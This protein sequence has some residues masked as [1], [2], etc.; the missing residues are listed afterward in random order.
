MPQFIA[1]LIDKVP[2]SQLRITVVLIS[3]IFVTGGSAYSVLNSKLD[4]IKERSD[5]KLNLL[6][7]Q[8]NQK[9]SEIEKQA[10]EQRVMLRTMSQKI[11]EI[12]SFYLQRGLGG[13]QGI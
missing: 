7:D 9:T 12:H 10:A 2:D 11:D 3:I 5:E 4:D 6:K 1:D 13:N 8:S